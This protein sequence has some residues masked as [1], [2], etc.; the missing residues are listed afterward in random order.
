M[1]SVFLL[2]INNKLSKIKFFLDTES[3]TLKKFNKTI[4]KNKDAVT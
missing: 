2:S 4:A 3:I 1:E